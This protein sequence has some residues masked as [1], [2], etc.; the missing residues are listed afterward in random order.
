MSRHSPSARGSTGD[1]KD[2]PALQYAGIVVQ[3]TDKEVYIYNAW[4]HRDTKKDVVKWDRRDSYDD[5]LTPGDWVM[6]VW[7]RNRVTRVTRNPESP[8][9]V[10]RCRRTGDVLLLTGLSMREADPGKHEKQL[11]SEEFHSV[12]IHNALTKDMTVGGGQKMMWITW[13]KDQSERNRHLQRTGYDVVW[14]VALDQGEQMY[15]YGRQEEIQRGANDSGNASQTTSPQSD[16]S[17]ENE[18]E[19][20]TERVRKRGSRPGEKLNRVGIITGHKIGSPFYYVWTP[21][22]PPMMEGKIIVHKVNGEEQI[23]VCDWIHF[24][25]GP[26][27]ELEIFTKR[28]EKERFEV[29]D[30]EPAPTYF[31]TQL[32]PNKQT[33]EISLPQMIM[34]S[35]NTKIQEGEL[36]YEDPDFGWI[37]DRSFYFQNEVNEQNPIKE[38]YVIELEGVIRR[39]KPRSPS[40]SAWMILNRRVKYRGMDDRAKKDDKTSKKGGGK[41]DSTIRSNGSSIRGEENGSNGRR[42]ER[43]VRRDHYLRQPTRHAGKG[44]GDIIESTGFVE[45][46]SPSGVDA[47]VWLIDAAAS[48]VVNGGGR[49]LKI[50]DVVYGKFRLQRNG[51]WGSMGGMVKEGESLL[52]DLEITVR[53]DKVFVRTQVIYDKARDQF[54]NPWFETVFDQ[55]FKMP[56][57]KFVDKEVQEVEITKVRNGFNVSKW[58]K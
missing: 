23:H 18:G 19:S 1:L 45:G 10:R 8:M 48:G 54:H 15:A 3:A 14:K 39:V 42:E 37:G 46:I 44:E 12:G 53:R 30:W 28:E 16:A 32:S 21:G 20:K 56:R 7:R 31:P 49:Y 35:G 4:L 41:D 27:D 36:Y 51:K 2:D 24:R 11:W 52:P 25:V 33:I 58:L 9:E 50:G 34:T 26:K 47:F 40:D 5:L 13:M 43:R 55:D 22:A 17:A 57:E 38:G 29:T 6:M